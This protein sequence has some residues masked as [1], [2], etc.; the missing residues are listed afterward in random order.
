MENS[1]QVNEPKQTNTNESAGKIDQQSDR[2]PTQQ[3]VNP[4]IETPKKDK[5]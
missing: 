2:T 3:P 1:H 4:Q 5:L